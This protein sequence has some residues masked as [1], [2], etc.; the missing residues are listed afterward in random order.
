MAAAKH[1]K[2][3]V[4]RLILHRHRGL[5]AQFALDAFTQGFGSLGFPV[6]HEDTLRGL[7]EAG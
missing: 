2:L 6:D 1:A 7:T 5:P 4:E 3:Q